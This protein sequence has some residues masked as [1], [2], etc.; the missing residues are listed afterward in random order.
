[1][2]SCGR[3]LAILEEAYGPDHPR[4]SYPLGIVASL[5]A[6]VGTRDASY[7]ALHERALAIQER[8]LRASFPAL[9]R[10]ERLAALQR[11]G[12]RRLV[13]SGELLASLALLDEQ[14]A[15]LQQDMEN[16]G[17]HGGAGGEAE[18]ARVARLAELGAL[19]EEVAKVRQSLQL[20]P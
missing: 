6:T 7:F 14:I 19:R 11:Q 13:E 16:A 10:P 4:L 1:M 3:A 17:M 9:T 12:S 8:W 5:R 2:C 15:A 20:E 18:E